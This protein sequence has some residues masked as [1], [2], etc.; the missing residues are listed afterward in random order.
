[1]RALWVLNAKEIGGQPHASRVTA[2][3]YLEYLVSSGGA[4]CSSDL[5]QRSVSEKEG[6]H[7]YGLIGFKN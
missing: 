3:R 5:W 2:R 7:S 6:Y 4:S 1:M